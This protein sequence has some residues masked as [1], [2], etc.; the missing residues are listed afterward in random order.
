[1]QQAETTLPSLSRLIDF[2]RDLHM[3]PELKYQ[4]TRTAEKVAA[5]L[6]SIGV[7]MKR[8]LGTTGIVASIHGEHR[9]A[10]NPGP[11]IGIR[12]DMDALPI[13]EANQFNHASKHAGCMHACGHDGHTAMLLGAAEL[14]AAN[15]AFD[16]TVHLIFQPAEEGGA[17]ALAMIDDGLFTQF[18]CQAVFAL[19]NWPFPPPRSDGCSSRTDYGRSAA[20]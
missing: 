11:A 6:A 20:L 17:G 16:G 7:P 13:T 2:R 12:A 1:M 19:H 3:H 14:L 10:D 4:E 18:P 5:Y 9:S 15:R 8:G